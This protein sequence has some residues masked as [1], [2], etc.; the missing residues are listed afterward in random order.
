MKN[1]PEAWEQLR[2]RIE[3]AI[4]QRQVAEVQRLIERARGEFPDRAFLYMT[5]WTV[6]C[7]G[8]PGGGR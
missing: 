6:L 2:Q 5:R 4:T 3:A 7:R 1:D 8:L